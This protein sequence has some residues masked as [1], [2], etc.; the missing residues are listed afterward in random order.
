MKKKK[1]KKK[2]SL[3]NEIKKEKGA[4]RMDTKVKIKKEKDI[5]TEDEGWEEKAGLIKT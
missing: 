4:N 1:L 3:K 5:K 2:L